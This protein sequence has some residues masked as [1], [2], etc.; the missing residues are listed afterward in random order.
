MGSR[1]LLRLLVQLTGAA[2]NGLHFN[3]SHSGSVALYAFSASAAVGVDVEAGRRPLDEIGLATRVFGPRQARRLAEAPAARRSEEF[4]REWVRTEANLKCQGTGFGLDSRSPTPS[5]PW[6][7]VLNL[8]P[9]A[10]GAVAAMCLPEALYCW[11]WTPSYE[12]S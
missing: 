10:A 11:E 7:V 6:N 1:A 4:L 3:L 5:S 8:G 9:H 12:E 2:R